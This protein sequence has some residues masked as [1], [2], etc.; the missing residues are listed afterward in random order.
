MSLLRI[1]IISRYHNI[2]LNPPHLSSLSPVVIGNIIIIEWVENY[3]ILGSIKNNELKSG[4]T[5]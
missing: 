3:K 2:K 1:S 5:M 4:I